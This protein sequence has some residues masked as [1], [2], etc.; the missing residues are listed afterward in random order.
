M[1]NRLLIVALLSVSLASAKTYTISVTQPAQAGQAQLKPGEYK[2][3]IEGQQVLLMDK[4]G[5]S[6]DVTAKVES[7][8]R[9]F[10]QTAIAFSKTG[11][12]NRI[13]WI[14]LGGSNIR[15]VFE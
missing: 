6:I 3:K 10:S 5:R 4:A 9:K 12:E 2:V 14:Q 11:G 8:D 13:Q 7:A 1:L 15:L